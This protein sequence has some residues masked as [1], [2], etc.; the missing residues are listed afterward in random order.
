MPIG[1]PIET[2]QA[3]TVGGTFAH[4]P[5]C[6]RTGETGCIVSYR[7][8]VAGSNA[9]P[10]SETMPSPGHQ[11]VCVNPAELVHGAPRPFSRALV[12]ASEQPLTRLDSDDGV[13]TPLVML[14]DFYRGQC[15]DG[16]AGYRYL[17]ISQAPAP[18]DVRASPID[19]SAGLFHSPLGLH[20]LDYQFALGDLLDLVSERAVAP[21]QG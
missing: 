3:E 16:P 9:A 5:V 7:S 10:P 20:L 14:R 4:L 21:P 13:M 11:S 18:G 2:N 19:L 6:T 12:P 8:Y 17:A 1:W 15:I